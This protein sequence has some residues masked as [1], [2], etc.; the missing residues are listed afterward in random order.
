VPRFKRKY[1]SEPDKCL[2]IVEPVLNMCYEQE[3]SSPTAH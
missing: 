2:D 1:V 3:V